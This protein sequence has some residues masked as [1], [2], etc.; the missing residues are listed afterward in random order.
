MTFLRVRAGVENDLVEPLY[1]RDVEVTETSASGI[2]TL[3]RHFL[4]G[5]CLI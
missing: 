5:F 3:L 4:Y 2:R 1:L